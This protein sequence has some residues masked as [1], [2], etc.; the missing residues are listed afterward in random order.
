MELCVAQQIIIFYVYQ[1]LSS[2]R[3]SIDLRVIKY[4]S[5]MNDILSDWLL[6]LANSV[7]RHRYIIT[8]LDL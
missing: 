4:H 8:Y 5:D 3:C 1:S 2:M 6:F 7:I